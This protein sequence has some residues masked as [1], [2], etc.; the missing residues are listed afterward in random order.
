MSTTLHGP[1]RRLPGAT[2]SPGLMAP[3]VT[4]TS[5]ATAAPATVPVSASTPLGTS[6][7][8]TIAPLRGDPIATRS[9]ASG[10]K[11]AGPADAEDP[12]DGE[13]RPVD[14]IEQA[15]IV[16]APAVQPTAGPGQGRGPLGVRGVAER[17]RVDAAAP[18]GQH[19]PGPE[20][21][22]AVVAR[23]DEQHHP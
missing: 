2:T 5:A 14:Q 21:I 1:A 8:T 20:G 17:E 7:A 6:T 18:T 11:G 4:V 16:G 22:A 10:A 23:T 9:A 3:N 19:R 13:V 12:V 15:R